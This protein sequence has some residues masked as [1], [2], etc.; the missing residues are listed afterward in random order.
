MRPAIDIGAMASEERAEKECVQRAFLF[1]TATG[2]GVG[3]SHLE[4]CNR[5]ARR[6]RR[7]GTV[8]GPAWSPVDR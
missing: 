3:L 8:L 1:T 6:H 5:Y 2:W 4:P 7:D